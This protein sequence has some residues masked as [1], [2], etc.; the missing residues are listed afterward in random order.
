M[1]TTTVG[2]TNGTVTTARSSLLAGEVEAGE[3]VRAG[4][5]DQQRQR[6][7]GGGLPAGEPQDV[8]DVRVAQHVG[9]PAELPAPVGLQPA[10]DDR[11]HRIGEEH[12][13]EGERHGHQAEPHRRRGR[14]APV[15]AACPDPS[16]PRLGRAPHFRTSEVHDLTHCVTVLGDRVR[17][18]GSPGCRPVVPYLVKTSGTLG[19]LA[20]R[21]DEHVAAACPPGT[22]C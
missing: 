16:R 3:D 8:P 5:R 17:G 22:S 9:D 19:V 21:V 15:R 10:G 4:Q 20:H 12:R 7:G 13:E 11:G 14:P 18:P 2:S 1:P 6:G